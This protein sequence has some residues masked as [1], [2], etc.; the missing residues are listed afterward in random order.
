MIQCFAST[1]GQEQQF[2]SD[3]ISYFSQQDIEILQRSVTEMIRKA[4]VLLSGQEIEIKEKE[5]TKKAVGSLLS[6]H[7]R[8]GKFQRA[9]LSQRL[10][11]IYQV[12]TDLD[13]EGKIEALFI[14][15]DY[16]SLDFS[17]LQV[18][19]SGFY[20]YENFVTSKFSGTKF[21]YSEF[22]N[23][24]GT[25]TSESFDPSMFD[26][27]CKLG[28]L[29]DTVAFVESSAKSNKALCESE[30]K[31]FFRSFFKGASFI[32]QKTMYIQFSGKIE[33]LAKRNFDSF[34]RMGVVELHL[35]KNIDKFYVISDEY[36]GSVYRFLNDN[37]M[38]SK[39]KGLVDYLK[40]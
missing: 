12:K 3:V 31:K 2:L 26:S 21:Y 32:D 5:T 34:I 33:K 29:S 19:D 25:Y 30:L 23:T 17:N 27:T 36:Q 10:R 6:I 39:I 18:W 13:S 14:Y 16:P 38:D 9:E 1:R 8:C 15:G 24:G 22:S 40:S 20:N 4:R 11:D 35:A 37:F 28:E 7:S